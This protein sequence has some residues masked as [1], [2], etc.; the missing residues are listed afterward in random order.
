MNNTIYTLSR[1]ASRE[2]KDT[3]KEEEIRS[4]CRFIFMD[5]FH[6]TNIDIHIKKHENLSESFADKFYD[7]VI[8]LK[9]G[10]P[11]QY[12]TGTTEF[13]GLSF[14]VDPSTLIPRPETEELV[15]WIKETVPSKARILDIGTGSGCIAVSLAHFFPD[16]FVT[17]IDLSEPALKVARHNALLNGTDIIFKKADI[18]R[19][20]KEEWDRYDLIVSNPPYVRLSEKS[21][22]QRQVVDFEPSQALFVSDEDPLIYYRKI[23]EFGCRQLRT[24]GLLFFEINEALGAE[25]VALLHKYGYSDI[26]LKKDIFGKER[27]VKGKK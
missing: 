27:F 17:A 1:Y 23:A 11:I 7:I 15:L 25:S 10:E 24:G 18:F 2:L 3:Y 26:E 16:S 4:I 5:V 8:R 22:M 19:Y 6:Y 9:Q 13:A 12:I 21:Y 20:E 14:S